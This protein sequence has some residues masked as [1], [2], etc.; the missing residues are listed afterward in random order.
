[1]GASAISDVVAED[2]LTPDERGERGGCRVHRRCSLRL[3]VH[4]GLESAGLVDVEVA[5]THEVADGLHGAIV[6]AR[7]P[8]SAP[9]DL[10]LVA[11]TAPGC[12]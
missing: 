3:G 5:F 1:M 8:P 10:P 7:K 9:R 2:R 4:A 11:A 12:C 6:K